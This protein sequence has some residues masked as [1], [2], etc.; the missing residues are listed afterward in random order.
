LDK[1]GQNQSERGMTRFQPD[2]DAFPDGFFNFSHGLRAQ[3]PGLKN[4][5]VWHAMLGYWG[6]IAPDGEL[7]QKF[8]T[9]QVGGR[10]C[11]AGDD[12]ERFYEEFYRYLSYQGIHGVKN[13]AQNA[14]DDL[15]TASARRSMILSYAAAWQLASSRWL[16]QSRIAC[17]A[18]HPANM[19]STMLRPGGVRTVLRNSDDFF[20]GV[21]ASHAWHVFANAHNAHL[22]ARLHALPDWDMFQ[23]RHAWSRYHAAARCLSGGPVYVTD[24]PGE[25][26]AAVLSEVVAPASVPRVDRLDPTSPVLRPERCARAARPWVPFAAAASL[27]RIDAYHG[28]SGADGVS[29]LGLFNVCQHRVAEVVAL[30]AFPGIVAGLPYVVRSHNVSK[31]VGPLVSGGEDESAAPA[32]FVDLDMRGVE[33][34]TACPVLE[35]RAQAAGVR[36]IANLGLLGLWTGAAAIH[37]TRVEDAVATALEAAEEKEEAAAAAAS[38][39][40]RARITARITALGRWGLWV[41]NLGEL[42]VDAD[43]MA[44]I[45]GMPVERECVSVEGDVLIIDLAKAWGERAPGWKNEVDIEVL[46]R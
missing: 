26:D 33:V 1:K 20:P 42:D 27:L 38:A 28:G 11:I 19:Y 4:I 39:I 25:H 14:L 8:K 43:M 7:A 13:D 37:D 30:D 44:V 46:I 35:V 22:T 5:L 3:Y 9:V 31:V 16:R 29:F 17:G 15:P 18:Q 10:T 6:A 2:P 45:G 32:A 36:K 34:L 23:T 24:S 21:D 12:V 40:G 41:E